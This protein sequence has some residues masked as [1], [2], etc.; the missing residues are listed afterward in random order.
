[1]ATC[2]RFHTKDPQILH[3]TVLK[4]KISLL[5]DQVP[6]ICAPLVYPLY[7]HVQHKDVSINDGP[8]IQ[9]WSHRIMILY[10]IVILVVCYLLGNSPASEFCTG[11][12]NSSYLP[13]YEDGTDRVFRNVG[14]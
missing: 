11:T 13:V 12:K 6:G 3:A 4:K 8:H 5:D 9:R 7:S 2:R 10:N 14:I 1:M